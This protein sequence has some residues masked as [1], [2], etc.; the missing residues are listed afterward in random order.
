[1]EIGLPVRSA[2]LKPCAGRLVVEWVTT[3]EYLL[4]IVFAFLTDSVRISQSVPKAMAEI[5]GGVRSEMVRVKSC[6]QANLSD[7]AF[8]FQNA[9]DIRASAL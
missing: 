7:S 2:V 5:A 1:M 4:L 9:F 6:L 8:S 3:S